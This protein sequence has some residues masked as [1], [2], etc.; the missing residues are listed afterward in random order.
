MSEGIAI[1]GLGCRYP[2]ARSPAELWETVMARRQAFRLVPPERLRLDDYRARSGGSLPA[3]AASGAVSGAAS[4]AAGDA[5]APRPVAA[6]PDSIP[7]REAAVLAGWE[8]DRLR[9]RVAGATFRAADLT[10]WLALEVAA[11]ALADAG[12][13]EGQGLPRDATG[14]L[15][16]NTLTGE[17][18]RSQLLRLRWPYVRRVVAA[19]L[20]EEGW[21][22]ERREE[23]LARLE[24]SFKAPF[25]EPGEES[26]AGA[27]S[28]TIAGRICNHFDLHGGGFTVDAACAS[29]LLAVAQACTALAAGDLDVALAGG[30]DLSLDPFELVG[31][32]RA[33][34]LA[35]G[36]M[37][38][39]DARSA[40]FIPGEGCGF[41]VLMRERQALAWGR[42]VHAV[43]RGWGISSDGHGGISRPEAAGQRLALARAYRRAGF[44]IGSVPLFEG[45]GTGTAVGDATELAALAQSLREARAALPAA[46]PQ[47]PPAAIGSIKANI[48]HTK[49]AAG[50]AG[51]LKA[52]L[53][54][55]SRV[56]PPATGCE[57]P[58]PEL[59]A[60]SP[61]LRSLAAAEPWPAGRPARAGVSAMGFGGVNVHVVVEGVAAGAWTAVGTPTAVGAPTAVGGPTVV[62]TAAAVGASAV[63]TAPV[64]TAAASGA[65]PGRR[66]LPARERALAA[67]PQDVELLV[68]AAP[69][70]AA[71]AARARQ[72]AKLAPRLARAELGDL[73]AELHRRWDAGRRDGEP[74]V[75]AAAG[76]AA[77]AGAAGAKT[78]A[79][80]AAVARRAGRPLAELAPAAGATAAEA[81]ATVPLAAEAP[82]LRV[83]A[84][85]VAATPQELGE[86][87]ALL[88]GW[89]E[90]GVVRR[91]DPRLGVFLGVLGE[92]EAPP[93]VGL[94]FTGQGSPAYAAGWSQ[95][96]GD[97]APAPAL[98]GGAL[99][100]RFED[101]AELYT[102]AAELVV[103]GAGRAGS[104]GSAGGA[105]NA[106]R[107]ASEAR[108]RAVDTA[109]AQPA[110]VAHS[111]AGKW[112]LERLGVRASVA[113]G[114][115][116]GE[117]TALCWAGACDAGACLRLAAARGL[118]M[119]ENGEDGAMASIGAPAAAVEELLAGIA[120][121]ASIADRASIVDRA[122]VAD[123]AGGPDPVGGPVVIA[124]FNGAART[125]V[126][127]APAAV[128][129]V[130]ERAAARGLAASR[131]QVTRAFHS[132][133]VAAAAP[134]LDRALAA[135]SWSPPRRLVAS[136]VTGALL[137]ADAD[138]RALLREQV[139]APVRFSAALAAARPHARLWI[140]VGPGRA[141]AE[142]AAEALGEAVLAL[143]AGGPSLAGPWSTAGALF[144]AGVEI[145]LECLFAGRFHRP[146]D[147][148]RPL[149][150]LANPCESAPLPA[151][152]GAGIVR[153]ASDGGIVDQDQGRVVAGEV[154]TTALEL[155][156]VLVAARA[157]LPLSA[158]RDES[159]LLS[160]LHLNSITVGQLV[161]EASRRLGLSPPASPTAY[162]TA[163]IAEVAEAL[164]ERLRVEPGGGLPGASPD[165]APGG[166][167]APNPI[168]GI[169]TWVRPFTVELVE[170]P[171]PERRRPVALARRL[172]ASAVA[173]GAGTSGSWQVF[174][175]PGDPL[176]RAVTAALAALAP[177]AAE[178]VVPAP[179][180]SETVPAVAGA[181]PPDLLVCLPAELDE[182]DPGHL[183]LFVAAA[184]AA[185]T[186]PA[187]R[188]VVVLQ[189]GGGGGGFARTVHLELPA[190]ATWLVDLPAGVDPAAAAAWV[191][192]EVAA[193][194]EP[195]G[196]AAGGMRVAGGD[197]AGSYVEAHYDAAGRRRVPRLRLLPLADV[198]LP[199]LRRVETVAANSGSVPGSSTGASPA[200]GYDRSTASGSG[201]GTGSSGAGVSLGSD[202]GADLGFGPEDVLLVTGGGKGIGAEC[203]LA[204]ARA[205]GARLAVLGRSDPLADPELAANL[206]RMADAG[207]RPLYLRA[208]VADETAVQA[209]VE[210]VAATLGPVTALLHAAGRNAPR[211]LGD[212]DE[213][214]LRQTLAP[215]VAGA[216]HLLAALA[217]RQPD[218]LRLIVGF[219]SIIARTG[220]R[221]Q[222]EYAL[223]NEW[224]ALLLARHAA[225]HPACRCLV[226]DWSVW[227][228]T[229]M[230]ERLGTLETLT[231]QG[232]AAISPDAG[233]EQLLR[234]AA[235]P[236][237]RGEVVVTGRFGNPPTLAIERAELPLLRFL[238]QPRIHYPGIELVTD[239]A[240]SA[241]SDPYLADHVFHG[242]P[243]LAAVIGLEA[244]AQVAAAVTGA[245]GLPRFEQVELRRPIAVPPGGAT[246]LRIAALVRGP[247][248]VEVAVR[249]RASGFATDHF[250]AFCR[251]DP[252][253]GVAAGTPAVAVTGAFAA[254]PPAAGRLALD[255]PRDLYG[256][257]LFQTGR[258]RRLGG[259]RRLGATECLAEIVP[260]GTARWFG[261]YLPP[262]LLLG[263]PAARDAAIH[264]IQACI[265]HAQLLPAAVESILTTRIA[266]DEPL[267]LAAR[268]RVREGD[269]FV[270]DL[271]LLGAD[272][273]LRERWLGLRLHAVDRTRLPASW[274]A[275]LLAPYLERRL[276][277]IFPRAHLRV[278]L[279]AAPC[280]RRARPD[281][282]P[283]VERLLARDPMEPGA[284]PAPRL[285]HRPD[286][287]P[288]VPA[289]TP[290][291]V[292]HGAGL[293]LAIVGS[294]GT[295]RR[296]GANGTRGRAGGGSGRLGCDLEAIAERPAATWRD[297][298]GAE[299]FA[300]AELIAGHPGERPDAAATRVWAAAEALH[301]LGVS[302]GAPLLLEAALDDGWLLLRSGSLRI[303]SF[304]V[305]VREL[306]GACAL[307]VAAPDG[308]D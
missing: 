93:A 184:R 296:A 240:V 15:L 206:A 129:A 292:A 282:A 288:E 148:D 143:D 304:E 20:A 11:A 146:F 72:L 255:P 303:A 142:M 136:T 178:P 52:T 63:A 284:A 8:F 182:R 293:I 264:G 274:N 234:L 238:E 35:S 1:V 6:D 186:S 196:V 306:G 295:N 247:G 138:P 183:G 111:L 219:G 92:G 86:R 128:A 189:Q 208:D 235:D 27:L 25:P 244:M 47:P 103:A 214:G 262:T 49:A 256:G 73:A 211:L 297:L 291:S 5:G 222:A 233:V 30:V 124:A 283:L 301:K 130:V 22:G 18:S 249:D 134:D 172:E 90:S 109:V 201:V 226:L 106:G 276:Q 165:A 155:L 99:A 88:A 272:G 273:S 98:A 62:G 212:L 170:Q 9:F 66:E 252:P 285:A 77:E 200:P 82:G 221:G 305:A 107:D 100:R 119:A 224:L 141:L 79:L 231:R 205:S 192:A 110:I 64:L 158:I 4:G 70:A 177:A 150:F 120:A 89:I 140:E 280:G 123:R 298:L 69:D 65:E 75:A 21:A 250:R 290:L 26:L 139:T 217:A 194:G 275:A 19:G 248:H 127:G 71:L 220:L 171:L 164:S 60:A 48:G 167:A 210:H 162:A 10:H 53:A 216:R 154:P 213:E 58:H 277:E 24:A 113:A 166:A 74:R 198:P 253:A 286:G 44:D 209:A 40:G 243:L 94:L 159:R 152:F 245:S 204:L 14:V 228:G 59:V 91:L 147:L 294:N 230:G 299:R 135:V 3:G 308:P 76:A 190:A 118:A 112:L 181:P 195:Q 55:A 307:A 187:A 12:F 168:A 31:F 131:L 2:D 188:R 23:L 242:E 215:K 57:E 191:A 145:D 153:P 236:A 125:V 38:V 237:V 199:G 251:F 32:A 41:V 300:L 36:E 54:V 156:R 163:T 260:D 259:Y 157:E 61:E 144:A 34:A 33:G 151:P 241:D 46:G 266:A 95:R 68:L 78:G 263:D 29:S 265:P 289:G 56:L 121:R 279:E 197:A 108:D 271:D 179:R 37:R 133:L 270:Y 137:A 193:G 101:L 114:H 115:S 87:A 84:A 122:G 207:V 17:M 169:D 175:V 174:A 132:P 13:E 160:D 254:P 227:S 116:L 67:P 104:A 43:I 105:A 223:A 117:L 176:A 83:R 96:C 257:I 239:A 51:L 232:I 97:A 39:Y 81:R 302:P 218:R 267:L 225:S 202:P 80:L 258:F 269:T 203:A 42:R 7:L 50:V 229:G 16:G 278:A 85:I 173:A 185:A 246:T 102:V 268:E 281:S 126:S 161:I 261:N 287:R 28:N 180:A 45:H 149:T